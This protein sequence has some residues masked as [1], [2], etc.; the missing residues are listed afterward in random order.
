MTTTSDFALE[1]SALFVTVGGA[2]AIILCL[3]ASWL[4]LR[5]AAPIANR[6]GLIDRPT[7][8]RKI[9]ARPTPRM[10]GLA[11]AA[12][13]AISASFSALDHDPD[14]LLIWGAGLVAFH[15]LMGAIDDRRGLPAALRLVLSIAACGLML[16]CNGELVI[17][18][19]RVG[20]GAS[21]EIPA[22]L[23]FVLTTLGIVFFIF[24][25]NLMDGRNGILGVNALWW[26]ALLQATTGLLPTWAFLATA[27]TLLAFLRFNLRGLLFAGDGGAY[28]VGSG[29]AML[30]LAIYA[31]RPDAMAF[32]QVMVLFLLPVLD[33]GRVLIRRLWLRMTPFQAD[34]SH[35]HHVLWRRA[36][37]RG[38]ARLYTAAII[39]PSTL[40]A[41]LPTLAPSILGAAIGFFF[42][43]VYWPAAPLSRA[44]RTWQYVRPV[45][46]RRHGHHARAA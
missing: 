30:A 38:A 10:G 40:A 36:G 32:D 35:L 2:L 15:F 41:L 25:V 11:F 7:E 22:A 45:L 39:V 4:I 5:H 17:H 46:V 16:A 6:L 44:A 29:T 33:A 27:V 18:T 14:P 43:L 20:T 24:A 12:T 28:V 42:M 8:A 3:I 13:L 21:L 26:L 34:N 23:A 19:L 1:D 9:H 37:D 31:R